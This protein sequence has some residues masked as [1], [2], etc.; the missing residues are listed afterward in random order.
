MANPRQSHHDR[1]VCIG[2][3]LLGRPRYVI[4]FVAQKNA[5]SINCYGDSDFAE[6]QEAKKSTSGGILCLGDHSIK[7]WSST[8]SVIA[9]STREAEL[10]AL[11]EDCAGGLGAKSLFSDLGLDLD[12][13]DYTDATT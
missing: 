10:Y 1:L 7:S 11:N 6:E 3:Y 9:L 5:F 13:Q 12:I 4:K 2:K 8:Q